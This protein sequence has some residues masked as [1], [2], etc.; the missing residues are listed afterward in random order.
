MIKVITTMFNETYKNYEAIIRLLNNEILSVVRHRCYILL[1]KE[2]EKIGEQVS[3][4]SLSIA[5]YLQLHEFEKDPHLRYISYKIDKSLLW[6]PF[7]NTD[8]KLKNKEHDDAFVTVI[9]PNL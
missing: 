1:Y 3:G 9:T 7:K 2:L 4:A 6:F 5:Y 8:F